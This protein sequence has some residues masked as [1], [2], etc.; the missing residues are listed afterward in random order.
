V[1]KNA[2]ILGKQGK[3]GKKGKKRKRPRPA[4]KLKSKGVHNRETFI[5]G[6]MAILGALIL[7]AVLAIIYLYLFAPRE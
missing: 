4:Y 6:C 2:K 1:G 5:R 3:G 7:I